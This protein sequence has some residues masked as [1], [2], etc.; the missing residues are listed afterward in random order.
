MVRDSGPGQ[1]H[2]LMLLFQAFG[3]TSEEAFGQL[4]RAFGN[5][6]VACQEV[7]RALNDGHQLIRAPTHLS[8]C[9]SGGG[10]VNWPLH[11]VRAP[12]PN[13]SRHLMHLAEN[14]LE[15]RGD[16]QAENL[17]CKVSGQQECRHDASWEIHSTS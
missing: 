17:A 13:P 1:V 7:S 16:C 8:G 2:Q 15:E 9:L 3:R 14:D 6:K 10:G 5:L 11:R 12:R 4:N